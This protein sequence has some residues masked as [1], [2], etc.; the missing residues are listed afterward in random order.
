MAMGTRKHQPSQEFRSL[1]SRELH[2]QAEV[3]YK[4]GLAVHGTASYDAA[5][6]HEIDE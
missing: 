4:G 1:V 2:L 6:G 3:P 5:A